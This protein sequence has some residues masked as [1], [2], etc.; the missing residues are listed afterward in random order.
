MLG[1]LRSKIM[2]QPPVTPVQNLCTF[3]RQQMTICEMCRKED[4][5]ED[6]FNEISPALS[7]N[8]INALSKLTANQEQVERQLKNM[9]EKLQAR[10]SAPKNQESENRFQNLPQQ[11]PYSLNS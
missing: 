2:E 5:P 11:Q 7:E 9:D 6:G 3:A 1:W 10:N 8:L 4:H